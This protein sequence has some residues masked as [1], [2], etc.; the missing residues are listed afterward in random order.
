MFF[1]K[2]FSGLSLKILLAEIFIFSSIL[3]VV[4]IYTNPSDPLFLESKYGYLFYLLPILVLSLYY[5][6]TAGVLMLSVMFIFMFLYYKDIKVSYFLWMM[7]FILV[8]SEFNYYWSQNLKKAEEK[9]KY[10]EDKLRDLSRDLMLLKLSHDQLEKQYIVKPVSI[11]ALIQEFRDR[12]INNPDEKMSLEFLFSLVLKLY[13]VESAAIVYYSL[14]RDDFKTLI[15]NSSNFKVNPENILIRRTIEDNMI[16][17]ISQIDEKSEYLA[18]IPVKKD[19][20]F[21]LFVIE[22]MNFLN[23]NIDTLLTINILMYYIIK[24]SEILSKVRELS[25]KLKDYSLDFLKEVYRMKELFDKFGIETSLVFFYVKTENI[26]FVEFLRINLRG[27]D[28]MDALEKDFGNFVIP[29]LLPFTPY[30]GARSFVE[31]IS[32]KIIDTYS[33]EFLEQNVRYKIF[34]L[35][36]DVEL[37][38][39]QEGNM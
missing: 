20:D 21:Y 32:K 6:L 35:K 23:L 17:Y 38:L 18:V 4:G 1:A 27:L 16:T 36:G 26:D 11:R 29:I 10:T 37:L 12:F 33:I 19:D 31:R 2:I 8:A 30:S 25:I 13:N 3:F 7:L 34:S 14:E 28:V 39:R 15:T 24:E 5:G 9:L 22:E